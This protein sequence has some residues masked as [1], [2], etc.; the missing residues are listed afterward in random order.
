MPTYETPGPI[1]A[2]LHVPA[3]TVRLLA[4]DR[5]DTRVEVRPRDAGNKADVRAA[6]QT[7]VDY[8]SRKLKLRAPRQ[9]G[10]SGPNGILDVVV[11]LPTGSDLEVRGSS[12]NLRSEGRLGEFR[13]RSASGAI[14]L[15]ATGPLDLHS[16]SGDVTVNRV[17]G[18][19]EVRLG[20]GDVRIREIDGSGSVKNSSGD[21]HVG[22]VAGDVRL[23]A[24]SG[25]VFVAV[26]N[27][28]VHAKAATG[29]VVL[30]EV[31]GGS[32]VAE[33][34]TGQL[35]IG[36]RESVAAWLDLCS[37]T[38]SAHSSLTT[39]DGPQQG[40]ETVKVEARTV[41]GDIVIRRS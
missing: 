36:I 35:E 14:D 6:E 24:A 11:E 29:N 32:V 39:T 21:L 31:R 23:N 9:R 38:G 30:A 12:V 1:S 17:V 26:A 10:A 41:S 37:Q 27:A 19:I 8:E 15:D 33:T 22:D 18:R 2:A 4:T 3:G 20:S 40:E 5:T 28:D 13:C 25:D 7:R 16:A 34:S